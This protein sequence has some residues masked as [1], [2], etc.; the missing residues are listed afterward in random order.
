MP[1]QM[2]AVTAR[3]LNLRVGATCVVSKPRLCLK[4]LRKHAPQAKWM[5]ESR[6]GG[7]VVTRM[8]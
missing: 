1:K 4:T 8:R 7:L 6:E 5:S 3:L 2:D